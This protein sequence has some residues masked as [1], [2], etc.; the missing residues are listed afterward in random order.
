MKA[1]LT[2]VFLFVTSTQVKAQDAEFPKEFIMHL[3]LHN[4]MITDFTGAPDQY[5]GG[6]QLVPQWT[7]VS[8]KVR[9]GMVADVYYGGKKLNAAFGPTFSFKL[10]SFKAGLFGSAGNLHIDVDH[11]WGTNK[12]RLLGAGINADIANRIVLGV[13]AHRDY[14]LNTWW[15]QNTIGFRIS[16]TKKLPEL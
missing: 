4:G 8:N 15:F 5:I 3:K 1:L 12:E 13:S 11:L 6:L 7:L 14:N 9:A 2:A 10:K 16:K